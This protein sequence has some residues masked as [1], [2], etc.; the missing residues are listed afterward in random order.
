MNK[1]AQTVGQIII[2]ILVIV[3]IAT[4]GYAASRFFNGPADNIASNL[5]GFNQSKAQVST[6]DEIRYSISGNYVEYFDG[7]EWKKFSSG[8]QTV[9]TKIISESEVASDFSGYYF[10]K[11]NRQAGQIIYKNNMDAVIPSQVSSSDSSIDGYSRGSVIM[12][13]WTI[14]SD[15]KIYQTYPGSYALD[16]SKGLIYLGN[17]QSTPF[18]SN[19]EKSISSSAASWRDSIFTKPITIHYSESGQDISGMFCT[20]NYGDYILVR[21]LSNQAS[22]GKC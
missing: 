5:P 11:S 16:P 3:V 20:E 4:V 15:G 9:G 12:Q 7:N 1:N 22:G 6:M 18:S 8:V 19:D 10:S 2:I 21:S 17:S 13:I 14:G